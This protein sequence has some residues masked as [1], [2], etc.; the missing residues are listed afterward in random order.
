MKNK[1]ILI[2]I[3]S[4]IA[5]LA[6]GLILAIAAPKH[7]S[8]GDETETENCTHVFEETRV[9]PTKTTD[10]YVVHACM[11]CNYRF[12]DSR[13]PAFGSDGLVY[14]PSI[15]NRSLY[16][17]GVGSCEDFE[18]VIP[19]SYNG[20]NISKIGKEAFKMCSLNALRILGDIS[21]IDDL[22][23]AGCSE[24]A[25]IYFNGTKL[26]WKSIKKGTGWD[27]DMPEYTVHC[28]DGDI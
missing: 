3:I 26:E 11:K 8:N 25:D 20:Q 5:A 24:L 17:A 19:D 9:Q 2:I 28:T 18:I 12:K 16:V 27:K 10:G 21:E 13:E 7:T 6:L 14:A 1:K 22:A 4:A 23:F 15:D